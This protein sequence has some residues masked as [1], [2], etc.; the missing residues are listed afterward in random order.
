MQIYISFHMFSDMFPHVSQHLVFARVSKNRHLTWV[1]C[2]WLTTCANL[3]LCLHMLCHFYTCFKRTCNVTWV[4]CTLLTTCA[5]R[6]RF[7]TCSTHFHIFTTPAVL[8]GFQSLRIT[9]CVSGSG[10]HRL[11]DVLARV[12]VWI[13]MTTCWTQKRMPGSQHRPSQDAWPWTPQW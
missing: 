9:I 1:L 6:H 3:H 5:T 10:L 13:R 2:T 12:A 7:H 8:F 11:A 4:L